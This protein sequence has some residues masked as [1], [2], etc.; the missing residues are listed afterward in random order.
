MF[1]G[2]PGAAVKRELE[3]AAASAAAWPAANPAVKR[4]PVSPKVS[5]ADQFEGHFETTKKIGQIAFRY[6]DN[7]SASQAEHSPGQ[8]SAIVEV[9]RVGSNERTLVLSQ[10]SSGNKG[11]KPKTG[12]R[13]GKAAGARSNKKQLGDNWEKWQAPVRSRDQTVESRS[14]CLLRGTQRQTSTVGFN[15]QGFQESGADGPEQT[16]KQLCHQFAEVGFEI[17]GWAPEPAR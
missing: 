8:S 9:R 3:W 4:E 1:G 14:C 5:P 7:G 16:K 12:P 10:H 13:R 11:G 6:P 2:G 15:N 17:R